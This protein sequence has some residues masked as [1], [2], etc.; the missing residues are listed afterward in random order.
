MLA[1]RDILNQN[2]IA[3]RRYF[4]P[5]LNKLPFLSNTESCPVSEDLSSRVVC[6]PLHAEL[7]HEDVRRITALINQNL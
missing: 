5:S 1:V 6:L 3:P 4:Y 2:D 7:P